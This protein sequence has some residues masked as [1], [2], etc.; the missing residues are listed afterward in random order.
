MF[1]LEVPLTSDDTLFVYVEVFYHFMSL[2][3]YVPFLRPFRRTSSATW[4]GTPNSSL[5]RFFLHNYNVDAPCRSMSRVFILYPKHTSFT[6]SKVV[7]VLYFM[8]SVFPS[9]FPLLSLPGSTKQSLTSAIKCLLR[10]GITEDSSTK[11]TSLN[12]KSFFN[13]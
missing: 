1:M 11:C 7:K 13:V 3:L 9:P 12:T 8:V 5:I 2:S 4:F 6:L 10:S